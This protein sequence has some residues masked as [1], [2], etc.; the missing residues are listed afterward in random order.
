MRGLILTIILAPVLLFAMSDKELAVAINLA[1]KQRMLTQKMSKEALLIFIGIDVEKN[2]KNLKGTSALFERT[3]KGLINSDKSLG[4][5]KSNNQ[6][7]DAKLKEV[8]KLWLPFSKKIEDVA[9]FKNI[10]DNTFNYIDKYNTPLLKKMNEAVT[11]YTKLG[12][13]GSSKLK[14]ANDIN[15]AGKQRMLTQRIAKDL[16][17]Y[18]AGINPKKALE[19]L[20][21]SIKL[22][23]KTL[24]GL[25][26]KDKDLNLIGTK[27]PKILKQL[28]IVKQQWQEAKPLIV[29]SIKD[30]KNQE[31]TKEVIAKLDATKVQMNKAVELYT[32][33]LNRQKQIMKLNALISGFMVKKDN[34]K[35]L[36][37]L[38]GKQRMLTQRIAKLSIECKL[39]I[40][41]KSCTK[42]QHFIELYDKTLN[43]FVLGDKELSLSP[44]KSKDALEQINKI[45]KIW[46]PFKDAA[47]KLQLSKGKD[48]NALKKILSTNN[49]LLKESNNLVTVLE[50][51][52]SK[53]LSYIEKAQLKI[54]NIAGRER[55]L[56]QKMTKE[57]LELKKLKI[58]NANEHMQKSIKLFS[59]SLDGL[60]KGSKELGLPAVTNIKIKEQLLKVSK[61]WS[62]IMTI[63]NK[64]SITQKE[65]VLLLKINPILLKEMNKGVEIIEK[66][67]DY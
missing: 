34:S 63:Y 56:T 66:S 36:I 11:L 53:K 2:A 67:T 38:A 55:M 20:T 46:Q 19:S 1:G 14:M 57:L 60:I 43:G 23:D 8:T 9:S 25:Y 32:K 29:K 16:L 3:L 39:N 59:S 30:K 18:Q 12:S 42:L 62:K 13:K 45:K 10:S 7:I 44:I 4:L 41:P 5:V 51:E 24:N 48:A 31:L 26:N 17:L 21:S 50:K 65:L 54:V 37:N 49:S 33:S 28:D 52:S 27:L 61:L 35:H 22:F 58:A 40:L 47:L 64:N 15:L 6:A